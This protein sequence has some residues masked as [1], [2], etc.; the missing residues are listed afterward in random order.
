[1]FRTAHQMAVAMANKYAQVKGDPSG[2][3]VSCRINIF[4]VDGTDIV[5][6]FMTN[7]GN[8]HRR[9]LYLFPVPMDQVFSPLPRVRWYA[10]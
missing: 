9:K 7:I 4:M 2:L 8:F 6:K 10:R 5:Q 3:G 1:M